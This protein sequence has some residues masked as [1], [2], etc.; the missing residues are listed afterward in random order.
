MSAV[1]Y[2]ETHLKCRRWWHFECQKCLTP[3]SISNV[4]DGGTANVS[5]AL[6]RN[7]LQMST[8]VAL[9]MSALPYS[10][11]HFKCQRC[12][13][14]KSISNVSAGGTAYVSTAVT[15][16]SISNVRDSG[17]SNVSGVLFINPSQ[18]AAM[19]ALQM[20]AESYTDIHFK[21]QRLW[22]LKCQ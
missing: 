7:P 6:L 10:S 16:K 15:P 3:K 8:M 11:I 20:S 5:T 18:M 9:R 1:H 17:T 21:C 19:V 13:T 4:S 14:L 22:H 2:P 12:V